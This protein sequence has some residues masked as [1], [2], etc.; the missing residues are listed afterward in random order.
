MSAD[1]EGIVRTRAAQL[2]EVPPGDLDLTV[3]LADHY[4]LTSLTKVLLVTSV[5]DEAGVDLAHLTEQD[6]GAV[7]SGADLVAAVA[8][9]LGAPA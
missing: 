4:G 7:R 2:V 9:R 5:C 8:A 6:V 1:L 3:D